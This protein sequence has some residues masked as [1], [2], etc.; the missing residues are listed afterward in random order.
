MNLYLGLMS[1]TSMDAIDAVLVELGSDQVEVINQFTWPFPTELKQAL[2]ASL[3][4]PQLSAQTLWQLDARLGEAFADAALACLSAAA[5]PASDVQAIGCHGQTI[6]HAPKANPPITVQIGDPNILAQRCKITTIADF[7]RR[8]LAAGGE[9]APLAPGFHR[10]VFSKPGC[11]RGILNLGGIAN[12]SLLPGDPTQPVLGFDTGPANTLLDQWCQRHCAEEFDSGG[13]FA[14]SGVLDQPLLDRLLD[15]PYFQRRAPKSTGRDYF[16]MA[17]LQQRLDSGLA[18]A[19]VQR[20]LIELTV[21]TVTEAIAS[22]HTG[23]SELFVCGGGALNPVLMEGL[24]HTLSPCRVATTDELGIPAKA[25]EGA[26][27]AW[28]AQQCLERKPGNLPAVTGAR[29]SVVLGAI[30]PA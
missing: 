23:L 9:G 3:D 17:W 5:I 20:T 14:A 28:L 26:A 22:H 27:F 11:E 8:D 2:E 4:T 12:I 16:D 30:Y 24:G 19:D 18:P 25:V 15:D 1:G 10:G 21:R 6:F 7:R 29:E 13:R